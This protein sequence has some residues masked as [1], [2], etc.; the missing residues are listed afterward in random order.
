[1][2]F[3]SMVLAAPLALLLPYAN[4]FWTAILL[5][6]IGFIMLSSFSVTVVYA[7]MLVPGKIGT[8]SGLITGLAFGLGGVGALVLGNWIDKVGITNIMFLC[9]FL[10]LLGILTFLLPTD[11]TLNRWAEENGAEV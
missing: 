7:Q 2:I 5:A 9:G 3:L 1:M 4:Q 6:I 11:K 10:P 8:V